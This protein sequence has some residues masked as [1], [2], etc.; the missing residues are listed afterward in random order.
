MKDGQLE[1]LLLAA[2]RSAG[3]PTQPSPELADRA[4]NALARRRQRRDRA[5][6]AV[7]VAGCYVAGM[8]TMWVAVPSASTSQGNHAEDPS[9]RINP[10]QASAGARAVAQGRQ[11]V[12]GQDAQ[13]PMPHA[14]SPVA[15]KSRYELLREM[16]DESRHR[17]DLQAAVAFYGKALDA[18][19]EVEQKISYEQDNWLLM[20]LKKDHIAS[21]DARSQGDSI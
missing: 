15:E 11:T 4:R 17:G 16:G 5:R 6:L 13:E 21:Q 10:A 19:T 12:P 8:L 1:S 2:D 7:V 18:A 9:N 20:S 14:P 3:A